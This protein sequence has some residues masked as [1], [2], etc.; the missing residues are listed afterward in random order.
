[1]LGAG[2]IPATRLSPRSRLLRLWLKTHK[3]TRDALVLC[4]PEGVQEVNCEL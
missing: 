2:V 4:V 1:M 3:A